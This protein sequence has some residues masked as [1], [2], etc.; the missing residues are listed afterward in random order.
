MV[1]SVSAVGCAAAATSARVSSYETELVVCNK[2]ATTLQQSIDCE[3]GVRAR[4]GRP[5]RPYP[6]DGGAQ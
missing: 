2:T 6:A 5:V 4:Y 1:F 3:N